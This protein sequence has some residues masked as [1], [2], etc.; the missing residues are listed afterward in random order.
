MGDIGLHFAVKLTS[1][2]TMFECLDGSSVRVGLCRKREI[3]IIAWTILAMRNKIN[4]NVMFVDSLDKI[5]KAWNEAD[6]FEAIFQFGKD[7]PAV[8]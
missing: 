6:S 4:G 2:A 3:I 8:N 7:L 1:P 5:D